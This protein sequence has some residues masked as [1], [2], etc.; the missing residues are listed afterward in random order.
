M[1]NSEENKLPDFLHSLREQGDGLTGPGE[2]YFSAM[3]TKSMA[4]AKQPASVRSFGGRWLAVAATVLLLLVAGWWFSRESGAETLLADT[5]TEL[6]S[7]EL[8]ADINVEEIDAYISEQI[9][10]FTL[11]LYEEVPL[12]D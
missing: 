10:E 2:D 12:K 7:D 5:A 8:L 11:E 1:P 9:D 6:T 3:A 4:Q